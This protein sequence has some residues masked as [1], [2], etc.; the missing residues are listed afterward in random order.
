MVNHQSECRWYVLVKRKE[1]CW[2][3]A[4]ILPGLLEQTEHPMSRLL[5]IHGT[6]RT[7]R[8]TA[9]DYN[10]RIDSPHD[11]P[12]LLSL[13]TAQ[14]QLRSVTLSDL[15]HCPKCTE[16]LRPGV[17]WFGERL[18]AGAPDVVDDWISENDID[19]VITVGTSLEVFP[20]AEWVETVRASGAS[21][22]LVDTVIT[23][24]LEEM[25][26][27]G[28]WF[29]QGDAA[30]ILP[31]ILDLLTHRRYAKEDEFA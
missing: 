5:S 3:Y 8:C 21:L 19:L 22:A 29:F 11:V 28:D 27:H 12:F 13:S 25:L 17:V 31:K 30:E 7:I 1:S 24:K 6:L 26:D 20:A 10:T 2:T 4:N 9:C 14:N 18:A 16:L 23:R 15:P